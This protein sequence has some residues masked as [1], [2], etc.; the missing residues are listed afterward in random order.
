MVATIKDTNMNKLISLLLVLMIPLS[1]ALSFATP[2]LAAGRVDLT[3]ATATQSLI[4]GDTFDVV[5]QAQSGIQDV[6]GADV[7]LN[8]D[9]SR[10]EV[11]DVDNATAGIQISG[12]ATLA[13]VLWNSANNSSGH[14]DYSAGKFSSFPK[15]TFTIATVRFRVLGT[16]S[17]DTEV[18]F[19]TSPDRPTKIVG[20]T[21]ATD[22]TGTLTGS[23]YALIAP[24][25][26]GPPPGAGFVFSGSTQN[27]IYTHGFSSPA[28]FSSNSEGK[29]LVSNTL[30]TSDGKASLFIAAGTALLDSLSNPLLLVTAEAMTVPPATPPLSKLIEAYTFGSSGARFEPSIILSLSYQLESLPQGV[31]ETDLYLALYDG[32]SWVK[33]KSNIDTLAK[34]VKANISSF[35]TYALLVKMSQPALPTSTAIN[36]TTPNPAA[37]TPILT[38]PNSSPVLTKKTET[39]AVPS[40]TPLKNEEI[41][42][43]TPTTAATETKTPPKSASWNR[44]VIIVGLVVV[45]AI[46]VVLGLIIG[47][48]RNRSH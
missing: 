3:L 15:G 28:V 30:V 44:T 41:Q 40:S 21:K 46:S 16:T 32:A 37:T 42:S 7:F 35:G 38:P 8:F 33:L 1:I 17:A 20:D 10:L 9:S 19:S 47:T 2:L 11:V 18:T 12:G 45:L 39:T 6:V 31:N 25:I 24:V 34:T 26:P 23:A 13:T 22:V 43:I 36:S 14:I 5:I 27:I 29:T 4:L 48:R